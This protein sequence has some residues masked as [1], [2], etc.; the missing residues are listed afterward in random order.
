MEQEELKQNIAKY[1][2]ELPK[3]L[4]QSF[5]SMK[6]MEDL[7]NISIKY[8]LS[9]NQ[10]ETL[11]TETT[12]LLLGI[13]HIE[14]YENIVEKELKLP[15]EA[16]DKIFNEINNTILINVSE[17]LEEVFIANVES[18]SKKDVTNN[19]GEEIIKNEKM[20]DEV[21]L[22]PYAVKKVEQTIE[23]G[24]E[25]QTEIPKVEV[26][27]IQFTPKSAFEE[28]LKGPTISEHTVSDYSVPKKNTLPPT[29]EDKKI[30]TQ[31]PYR[32]AF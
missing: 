24:M 18:L 6:W 15:K 13:I 5:S 11:A 20:E 3:E 22:P 27:S 26:G 29:S 4:Q 21:P 14:E 23:G 12:L 8:S 2:S 19:K 32:E 28:K 16:S 10:L 17:K 30:P 25:K 31:D 7:K 1:Y 9:N